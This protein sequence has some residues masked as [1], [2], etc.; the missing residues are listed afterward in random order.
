MLLDFHSKGPQNNANAGPQYYRRE[1]R[2]S[3]F[4]ITLLKHA[5]EQN[6]L[7]R[8]NTGCPHAAMHLVIAIVTITERCQTRKI[9]G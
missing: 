8:F 1:T 3:L 5:F 4:A 9:G 6:V 2:P 7:F